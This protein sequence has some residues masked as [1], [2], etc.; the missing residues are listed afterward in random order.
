MTLKNIRV[1]VKMWAVVGVSLNALVAYA[2][3]SM[4]TV[5][6]VKIG[7]EAY[8][9][10]ASNDVLLA[11]VLPARLPRRVQ[12]ERLSAG[13]L[14]ARGRRRRG[15]DDGRP[16]RRPPLPTSKNGT[17]LLGRRAHG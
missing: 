6:T 2:W 17:D 10:I 11:D 16:A 14:R 8:R 5:S 3:I 12:P 1:A 4:S 9:K 13:R 7:G 15:R